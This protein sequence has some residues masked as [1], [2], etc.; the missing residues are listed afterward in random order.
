[1]PIAAALFGIP[2]AKSRSAGGFQDPTSESAQ[3]SPWTAP[4]AAA[5]SMVSNDG[6]GAIVAN[7]KSGENDAQRCAQI[8][9]TDV[10]IFALKLSTAM[11][12]A[13]AIDYTLLIISRY[14]DEL[15]GGAARDR[16][17]IAIM[18]TAGRTVLFSATT[19]ALS[20]AAMALFPM[21]FL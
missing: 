4:A 8:L 6:A 12:L 7:R 11:D 18:T 20:M 2:V 9:R 17:L 1:M 5:G 21:H 3:A 14:R 16:A 15:A 10:S 19:V 13:L